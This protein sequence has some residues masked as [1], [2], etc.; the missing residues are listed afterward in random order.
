[1]REWK[2]KNERVEEKKLESGRERMR[3]WKR[4]RKCKR[5]RECKIIRECRRMR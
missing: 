4:M 3:E 5:M 2:R 1:M